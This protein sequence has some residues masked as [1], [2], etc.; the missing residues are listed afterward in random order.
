MVL[1]PTRT[2]TTQPKLPYQQAYPQ[3]TTQPAPAPTATRTAAPAPVPTSTTPAP[4]PAKTAAPIQPTTNAWAGLLA[5]QQA[6]APAPQ[7]TSGLASTSAAMESRGDQ[8]QSPPTY[9]PT[10][11]NANTADMWSSLMAGQTDGGGRTV[12]S[13]ENAQGGG[14]S[15]TDTLPTTE[16]GG[17][18][19]STSS[20]E[21]DTSSG[22]AN[23]TNLSLTGDTTY[24]DKDGNRRNISWDDIQKTK[25]NGSLEEWEQQDDILKELANR[26]MA[27]G[28]TADYIAPW[29]EIIDYSAEGQVGGAGTGGDLAIPGQVDP[30]TGAPTTTGE[31]AE[32]AY[33]ERHPPDL[34][35]VGAEGAGEGVGGSNGYDQQADDMWAQAQ[36][37]YD[38]SLEGEM[39]QTYADEARAGRLADAQSAMLGQGVSGGG[40][41]AGQAQVALGGMQ[42]R[43]NTLSQHYKQGL[44]MKMAYLDTL[45]KRAEASKDRALQEKLQAEADKTML[46]MQGS[47][48]D[49]TNYARPTTTTGRS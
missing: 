2:A 32:T 5:G 15:G 33:D 29:Q 38:A 12:V 4:A 11:L 25:N 14:P 42:Q 10:T 41:Q 24:Y 35:I 27:G 49:T 3:P 47:N 31:V 17:S 44:T 30:V 40:Y 9:K 28:D 22:G 34:S 8:S 26:A 20:Y 7:P 46:A 23:S 43:Q 39:S 18:P 21:P 13:Q 6:P 16:A 19:T 1:Y 45:I 36:K 37:D 48:I